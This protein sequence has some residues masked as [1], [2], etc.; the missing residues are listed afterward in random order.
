[1]REQERHAKQERREVIKRRQ[2]TGRLMTE[3]HRRK[4]EA[5]DKRQ[6]DTRCVAVTARQETWERGQTLAPSARSRRRHH[7]RHR[8]KG[9]PTDPLRSA[10]ANFDRAR[11]VDA[12]A[13]S[14]FGDALKAFHRGE[15]IRETRR[16]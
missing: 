6:A 8:G 15:I 16:T 7:H 9:A 13:G 4:R 2:P 10:A 3:R 5:G 12:Q 11:Q 1:M 14:G